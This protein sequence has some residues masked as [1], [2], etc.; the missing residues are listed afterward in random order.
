MQNLVLFKDCMEILY[1][2]IRYSGMHTKL[3]CLQNCGEDCSDAEYWTGT[4]QAL[5]FMVIRLNP[6]QETSNIF[7][8]LK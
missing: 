4:E 6:Q 8:Y 3:V 2:A 1:E 5:V 7:K